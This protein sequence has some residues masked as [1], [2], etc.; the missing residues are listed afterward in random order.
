VTV[1]YMEDIRNFLIKGY[2]RAAG[3]VTIPRQISLEFLLTQ[4]GISG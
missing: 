3:F 2:G 4:S 1:K